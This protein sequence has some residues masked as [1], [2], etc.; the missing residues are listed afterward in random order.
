MDPN[1]VYP[2]PHLRTEEDPVSETLYSLEYRTKGDVQ[3]PST[4]E[5]Y[6][7]SSENVTI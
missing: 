7:P 2:T 1:V 4:P 6:A 3:K 5:W